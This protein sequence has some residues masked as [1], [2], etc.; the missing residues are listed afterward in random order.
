MLGLVIIL[1]IYFSLHGTTKIMTFP[2]YER[3]FDSY[4]F[5]TISSGTN[6]YSLQISFKPAHVEARYIILLGNRT[7]N[8][9][10]L[11]YHN[12]TLH[13]N[14]NVIT[15]YASIKINPLQWNTLRLEIVEN[16]KLAVFLNGKR[17]GRRIE[18]PKDFQQPLE[19]NIGGCTD[20]NK[21]VHFVGSMKDI[22]VNDRYVD[23]KKMQAL[24]YHP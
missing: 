2:E 3:D 5:S 17:I 12:G 15:E 1:L 16:K 14:G 18:L 22:Y 4:S 21:S 11:K 8:T 7:H 23:P 19:Y 24:K 10:F 20:T 13:I 6:D 9:L